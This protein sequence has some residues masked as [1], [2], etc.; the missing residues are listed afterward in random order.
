MS[1]T[2]LCSKAMMLRFDSYE[3]RIAKGEL[4]T[5]TYRT[6]FHFDSLDQMFMIMDDV[7]DSIDFPMQEGKLHRLD[8]KKED[9]PYVFCRL[10]QSDLCTEEELGDMRPTGFHSQM[11]VLVNKREHSSMQGT[12]LMGGRV[13]FFRSALELMHVLHEY[14]EGRFQKGQGL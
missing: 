5:L 3:D 2:Q 1:N 4:K 14:L 11:T 9:Q 7:M 10:D 8:E 12:V 6:P 13:I